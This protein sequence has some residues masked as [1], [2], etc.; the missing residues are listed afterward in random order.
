MTELESQGVLALPKP[1]RCRTTKDPETGS[2]V[3]L[4][5]LVWLGRCRLAGL[6]VWVWYTG[7][8]VYWSRTLHI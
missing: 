6:G 7:W 8:L 1:E 2:F 4:S 3:V 5:S